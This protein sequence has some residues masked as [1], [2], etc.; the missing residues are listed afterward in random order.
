[1]PWIQTAQGCAYPLLGPSPSDID[2][3]AI[4]EALSKICRFNG[5]T[6]HFYS[7]AQHC[8]LVADMLAPDLRLHG[9]LHDAHEAFI[10]D[11]PSATIPRT[12]VA[13]N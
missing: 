6:T 9:L 5:H 12:R 3:R 2:W 8:A 13:R 11:H 10:G 7:V 4:A 1:M